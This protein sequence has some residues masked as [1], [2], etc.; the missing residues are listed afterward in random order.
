MPSTNRH[1]GVTGPDLELTDRRFIV[2]NGHSR[3]TGADRPITGECRLVASR[4]GVVATADGTV[5]DHFAVVCAIGHPLS[6]LF[7]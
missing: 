2:K 7:P 5:A 6:T 1:I 4:Y 3:I